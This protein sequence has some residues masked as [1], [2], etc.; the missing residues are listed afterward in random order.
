MKVEKFSSLKILFHF[1]ILLT[2]TDILTM[3]WKSVI[4]CALLTVIQLG[5]CMQP[6]NL[7]NSEKNL[8]VG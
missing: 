7:S 6:S 8:K 2:Q 4:H 1:Q 3:K 5:K